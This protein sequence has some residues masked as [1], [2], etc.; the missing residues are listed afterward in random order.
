M[1]Q[2][3]LLSGDFSTQCTVQYN[4]NVTNIAIK[5]IIR[6]NIPSKFMIDKVASEE[7]KGY[8][9]M[10]PLAKKVVLFTLDDAE[11]EGWWNI[12]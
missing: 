9:S 4:K 7:V 6:F 2:L 8:Q 10:I 3:C 11:V 12:C 1:T 5:V